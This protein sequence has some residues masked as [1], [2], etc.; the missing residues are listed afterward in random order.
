MATDTVNTTRDAKQIRKPLPPDSNRRVGDSKDKDKDKADAIKTKPKSK[1]K[2]III[3][4]V[5]LLLVGGGGYYFLGSSGGPKPVVA[6][7]VIAMD[8]MTLN[9][10]DNH[11]LRLKIGL[12]AVAGTDETMDTSKAAQLI[13]SQFS[14]QPMAALSD[15]AARTKAKATLLTK[16]QEAYPDEIMD[17]YYTEFV[18]Q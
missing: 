10:A 2:L 8:N 17:L 18:M 4:V 11:F 13:I 15:D 7:P 5:A 6:G 16:L 3:A 14:N 1:K 9:L 12:Q